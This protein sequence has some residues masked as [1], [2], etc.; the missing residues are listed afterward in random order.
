MIPIHWLMIF[1]LGY[2]IGIS[3]LKNKTIVSKKKNKERW[4]AKEYRIFG[5]VIIFALL[6]GF[7]YSGYSENNKKA[8]EQ[9]KFGIVDIDEQKYAVIDANES[10]MILQNCEFDEKSLTIFENTYLCVDNGLN[11]IFIEF[12]KVEVVK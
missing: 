3:P 4:G 2:C 1:C 6:I 12:E 9:R 8:R 7:F 5:V 10:H 11:I